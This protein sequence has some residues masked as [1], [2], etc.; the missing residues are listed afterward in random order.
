MPFHFVY[1]PLVLLRFM[2]ISSFTTIL[3]HFLKQNKFPLFLIY[4]RLYLN[5]SKMCSSGDP[6]LIEFVL[7]FG[8]LHCYKA[9]CTYSVHVVM[10]LAPLV[11][12]VMRVVSFWSAMGCS[13]VLGTP[14]CHHAFPK[15]L[16]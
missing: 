10:R 12:L 8:L 3:F 7:H 6:S 2:L 15:P 13:N 5:F 4:H 16:H 9:S 14:Q 11:V 1:L